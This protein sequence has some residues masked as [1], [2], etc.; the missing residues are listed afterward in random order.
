MRKIVTISREFGSG[1]REFGKRLAECLDVGYYDSQIVKMLAEE[2][3][4]DES[5]LNDRLE[6]EFNYMM[7]VG[8]SFSRLPMVYDPVVLLAKQH[9]IIKNIV[10]DNDCVIIGRGA[11]AV[12]ADFKPFKIFVYADMDAKIERCKS[13]MTDGATLTDKEIKRKIKSI[14]KSRKATHDLYSPYKW[15]DKSA[16]NL[17]INTTGIDIKTIVPAIAQIINEYFDKQ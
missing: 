15:G 7:S 3:N 12:L 9:N 11:D 4:L 13:R 5:F 6:N 10:R 17:C 14:D 16:Y 1:G 2:T 8:R